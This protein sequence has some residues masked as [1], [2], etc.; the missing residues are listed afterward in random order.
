MKY[1]YKCILAK[2]GKRYYKNVGGKWKRISNKIGEKAEKGKKKYRVEE[3]NDF[4]SSIIHSL[5]EKL[6]VLALKDMLKASPDMRKYHKSLTNPRNLQ[7][8]LKK[9]GYQLLPPIEQY[10]EMLDKWIE[11][12]I[13][14]PG[15]KDLEMKLYANYLEEM[16]NPSS[17]D[18]HTS[19]LPTAM[20]GEPGNIPDEE[21]ADY[22]DDYNTDDDDDDDDLYNF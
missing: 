7:E 10:E 18:S 1:N 21:E 13:V 12:G 22:P 19:S 6:D 8:E 5:Y 3:K 14:Y 4:S 9:E 2:N 16:K 11:E 17:T 20:S 15:R